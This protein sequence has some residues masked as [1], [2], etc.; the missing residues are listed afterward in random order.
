M[1]EIVRPTT[2]AEVAEVLA[3][4]AASGRRVA[5]RGGGTNASVGPSP[6]DEIVMETSGFSG[7]V[8][9]DPPELVLTALAGTPL[10]EIDAL[11]HRHGQM[12]AF[13][14]SCHAR[15]C[16]GDPAAQTLGG[17]LATNAAGPRRILAGAARDHF[18]GFEAVS[19]RGVAFKAGGRVVKNVTGYDLPKLLAG[20]WGGLAVLTAVTVKVLPRPPQTATLLLH[21]LS[22]DEAVAAMTQALQ[23]PTEISAA[24]HQPAVDGAAAITALRLE[25]FGPSIAA[26]LARLQTLLR[27]F[28]AA[29]V[30][31]SP[32]ALAF[33]QPW[34][35]LG[36]LALD[37]GALWRVSLPPAAGAAFTADLGV[38]GAR[39]VYHWG[40]ALVLLTTPPAA[41]AHADAVRA[42]AARLGGHATL[43]RPGASFAGLVSAFPPESAV[44][45]TLARRIKGAFDPQGVLFDRRAQPRLALEAR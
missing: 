13:E 36:G 20:S 18:L 12:L 28:G 6:A 22:D 17:V 30:L 38:S 34:L 15:L 4:A 23:T 1:A 24:M 41:D 37:D 32:A 39:W 9:Y 44:A 25:G 8:D 19:G 33:W 14:P 10:A 45:V 27:P 29:E 11:L 3:G 42:A 5:V 35:T 26:R 40:G 7:V 2:P 31:A 43:L 21:G 16:G